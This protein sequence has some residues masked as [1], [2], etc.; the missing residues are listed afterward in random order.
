M[1]NISKSGTSNLEE[2]A[3]AAM[4]KLDDNFFKE[5]KVVG[6]RHWDEAARRDLE[7][8]VWNYSIGA[9]D[10]ETTAYQNFEQKKDRVRKA[11]AKLRAALIELPESEQIVFASRLGYWKSKK[12][13]VE[14]EKLAPHVERL[15]VGLEN[16]A[17]SPAYGVPHDVNLDYFIGEVVR[18][19]A[20]LG[21]KPGFT[22]DGP[23]GRVLGKVYSVLPRTKKFPNSAEAFVRRAVDRRRY[24][25]DGLRRPARKIQ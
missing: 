8:A 10:R 19:Y 7:Y 21:G 3:C 13:L 4:K 16:V 5:L 25:Q 22:K 14:M 20:S 11:A 17:A 12:G 1:K 23:L 24:F 6:K 15:L 9:L 18:I 2:S